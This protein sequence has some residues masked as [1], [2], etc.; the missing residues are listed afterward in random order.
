[1]GE[2][3]VNEMGVG[4]VSAVAINSTVEAWDVL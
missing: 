2:C 4:G 1:M 3:S